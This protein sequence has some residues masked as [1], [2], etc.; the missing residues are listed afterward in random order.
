[1]HCLRQNR[2]RSNCA[3]HRRI[4]PRKAQTN[5]H[6]A[7]FSSHGR[8]RPGVDRAGPL[9][10][11]SIS[12]DP[13]LRAHAGRFLGRRV[14]TSVDIEDLAQEIFPREQQTPQALAALQKAEIAKLWPVIK[15]A[16]IK[17]E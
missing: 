4:D 11:R 15:S 12:R 10:N 16:A 13:E 14:R 7:G 17:A 9:A 3:S 8:D 5:V 6:Q 2:S 1:M